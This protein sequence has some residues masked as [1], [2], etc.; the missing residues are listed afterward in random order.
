[1][2]LQG[3][4]GDTPLHRAAYCGHLEV[5]KTLK[6]ASAFLY[7]PDKFGMLAVDWARKMKHE[8]VAKACAQVTALDTDQRV[9][10][11]EAA[12]A[13]HSD[14][15]QVLLDSKASMNLQGEAGDTPLHR[16][17]YCG[18]LEVVKTLRNA[19]A[20]LYNP[21][22]FGMF[23]IDWARKM[24]HEAV[25]RLLKASYGTESSVRIRCTC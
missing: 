7:I 6:N 17:A 11:H 4:A 10:L 9:S 12:I 25:V 8:A 5:V 16:A 22:K 3:E 14:I 24:E 21:D 13:G 23:A 20:F 18:H 2:N 19:R 1:M 15:V